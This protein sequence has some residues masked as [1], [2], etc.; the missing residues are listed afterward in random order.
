MAHHLTS[1]ISTTIAIVGSGFSGSLVAANLLKTATRPLIVKLIES[2]H[3]I[4]K[5]VA[6]STDVDC[7][8]L[9]IA[10]SKRTLF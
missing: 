3:D 9:N 1:N 10:K 5:G 4:G 6:Y 7:H 2:K 8:L